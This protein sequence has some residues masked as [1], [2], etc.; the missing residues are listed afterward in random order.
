[1]SLGQR[2]PGS[3]ADSDGEALLATLR[4]VVAELSEGKLAASQIDPDAHLF[5][6]GYV[7]SLSA[8]MF[9]AHVSERYGVEI[10]DVELIEEVTT[11]RAVADRIRAAG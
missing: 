1:M 3:A 8:V 11:L 10:E 5:D 4:E 9:L 7:N 2:I 6:Y